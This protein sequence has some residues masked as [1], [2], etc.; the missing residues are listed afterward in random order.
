M[1]VFWGVDL[2]DLTNGWQEM[3]RNMLFFHG[4]LDLGRQ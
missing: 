4:L 1:L 3:D 2:L